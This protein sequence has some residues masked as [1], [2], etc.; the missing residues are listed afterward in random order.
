[1]WNEVQA[2]SSVLVQARISWN[3]LAGCR[4]E[5]YVEEDTRD[6]VLGMAIRK[7]R[8]MSR[9]RK[10]N[11]THLPISERRHHTPKVGDMLLANGYGIKF[12]CHEC[13]KGLID[14]EPCHI[15]GAPD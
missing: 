8:N 9:R 2:L 13:S 4:N 12:D 3:V 14:D 1:M 5:R 15:C 11:A 7:T 10:K 6:T